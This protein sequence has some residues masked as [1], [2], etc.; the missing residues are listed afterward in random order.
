MS[1]TDVIILI[2]TLSIIALVVYFSF[3]KNKAGHC[4]SCS[5]IQ[6]MKR[7][8][9]EIEKDFKKENKD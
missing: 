1:F 9:K 7:L 4:S 5:E 8:N 3:I 2:I 6:K